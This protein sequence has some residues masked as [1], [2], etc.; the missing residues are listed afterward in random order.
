MKSLNKPSP[1]VR[2]LYDAGADP[3]PAT[4]APPYRCP[5]HLH[6]G[7]E[8]CV[9]ARNPTR[10]ALVGRSNSIDRPSQALGGGG[11]SG[12]Q[13]GG[14]IGAGL[15][16]PGPT[17]TILRRKN[18]F[19]APGAKASH[20]KLSELIPRFLRLSALVASE[21]G[22]EMWDEAE[23]ATSSYS[24]QRS[25]PSPSEPTTTTT[26]TNMALDELPPLPEPASLQT[27]QAVNAAEQRK[28][29]YSVP[30]SRAWYMLLAGLLTRAAL[31]GY[32]TAGWRG[33]GA[34]ECLLT[35]GLGARPRDDSAVEL[36]P[37]D[38]PVDETKEDSEDHYEEFD[39][40]DLPNL[41]DAVKMLFPSLRGGAPIQKG[42][43]EEEYELEM[44]ERLRR[45]SCPFLPPL[46]CTELMSRFQFFDIP[47]TTPDLATHMEDLAWQYPAEPV[48][49]AAVRYCEAIAK[50]RGKP[51]LETVRP[52]VYPSSLRDLAVL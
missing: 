37:E 33:P 46:F 22:R 38:A 11:L 41:M 7:C 12:W 48:E 26:T 8:I 35:C 27:I 40:Y 34:V 31:E 50:W 24:S 28:F 2:S 19:D 3:D 5:R 9:E 23:S 20:T 51:E 29:R 16:R 32:M 52:P 43:P 30:P 13:E 47:A 21:L 25:S 39:P 49:R 44:E 10:P 42:H 6:T 18:T 1:R 15:A 14:G 36:K 4:I 17:G 45:V